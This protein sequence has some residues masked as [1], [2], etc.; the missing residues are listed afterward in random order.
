MQKTGN[1]HLSPV[2]QKVSLWSWP[3]SKKRIIFKADIISIIFWEYQSFWLTSTMIRPLGSRMYPPMES[4][5]IF[6]SRL[7]WIFIAEDSF[8]ESYCDLIYHIKHI[9]HNW[10]GWDEARNEKD[11]PTLSCGVEK[12]CKLGG[13]SKETIAGHLDSNTLQKKLYSYQIVCWTFIKCK[14]IPGEIDKRLFVYKRLFLWQ[15]QSTLHLN[16]SNDV[17][18]V[19]TCPEFETLVRTVRH[20]KPWVSLDHIIFIIYHVYWDPRERLVRHNE[21]WIKMAFNRTTGRSVNL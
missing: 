15:R 14:S 3:W 12:S 20:N 2:S 8:V 5:R 11:L 1:F 10:W 7:M 19:E 13:F 9:L 18:C 6:V 17:A 21:P 16:A 4:R